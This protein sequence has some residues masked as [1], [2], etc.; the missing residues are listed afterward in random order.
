MS[1]EEKEIQVRLCM[2]DKEPK[3][4]KCTHDFFIGLLLV[5]LDQQGLEFNRSYQI[6]RNRSKQPL[7]IEKILKLVSP[8]ILT[9]NP[10]TKEKQLTF[11]QEQTLPYKGVYHRGDMIEIQCN[12]CEQFSNGVYKAVEISDIDVSEDIF[13]LDGEY[14]PE[15][16][17]FKISEK[18]RKNI[19]KYTVVSCR[20]R[21]IITP[22]HSK[23]LAPTYKFKQLK[24]IE[25]NGKN[26]IL[27]AE[28]ENENK[29]IK[30]REQP[31]TF[32]PL[33]PK[34]KPI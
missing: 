28:N 17:T 3:I 31:K 19:R 2:P 10:M 32:I 27:P 15:Y 9:W 4:F 34:G 12:N 20:R 7:T 14:S 6:F 16:K 22:K 21:S 30:Y 11:E 25:K 8:Y 24:I 33:R 29:K 5:F 23:K 26:I 13:I 18:K 1:Q